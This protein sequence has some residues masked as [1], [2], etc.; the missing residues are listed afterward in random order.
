MAKVWLRALGLPLP[1]AATCGLENTLGKGKIEIYMCAW[2]PVVRDLKN[3]EERATLPALTV[4][5]DCVL[6]FCLE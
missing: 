6:D 3:E 2:W 4:E 1:T 5:G